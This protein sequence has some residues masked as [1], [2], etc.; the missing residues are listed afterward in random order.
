MICIGL[1]IFH[2]G[3]LTFQSGNYTFQ[4]PFKTSNTLQVLLQQMVKLRSYIC[5]GDLSCKFTL[6]SLSDFDHALVAKAFT[7][8]VGLEEGI[9]LDFLRYK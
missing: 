1:Y 6:L 8:E 7:E 2:K 3:C 9:I 5:I 4:K